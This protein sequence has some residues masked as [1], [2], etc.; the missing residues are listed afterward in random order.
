MRLG[1]V[2]AV[3][4]PEP[5]R[6]HTRSSSRFSTTGTPASLHLCTSHPALT[7]IHASASQANT[8]HRFHLSRPDLYFQ[9]G[10]ITLCRSSAW[11][12]VSGATQSP[13]RRPASCLC[14][15]RWNA[16]PFLSMFCPGHWL[17]DL[18]CSMPLFFTVSLTSS[19]LG[20]L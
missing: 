9:S 15:T 14:F 20:K 16:G 5:Q 6:M 7:R 2:L 8:L 12:Q 11:D 17:E 13:M 10:L 18:E 4:C 3:W 19:L 1:Q